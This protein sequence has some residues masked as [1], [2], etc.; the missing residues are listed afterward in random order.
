MTTNVS[1]INL[2]ADEARTLNETGR[3]EIWMEI[4][5]Q[6][7]FEVTHTFIHDSG[8]CCPVFRAANF[9]EGRI[10][11]YDFPHGPDGER[12]VAEACT[13]KYRVPFNGEFNGVELK[14]GEQHYLVEFEDEVIR[15][16]TSAF[17]FS[18]CGKYTA[19]EMPREASRTNAN[20]TTTAEQRDGVWGFLT[21][22]E[23]K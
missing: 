15:H 23:R 13:I 1:R 9:Q 11:L 19:E 14:G 2:T 21:V 22:V 5:P 16:E 18:D 20:I 10:E 7:E 6:P 12:W 17:N 8:I 3:V 4:E